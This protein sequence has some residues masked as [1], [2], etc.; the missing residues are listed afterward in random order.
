VHFVVSREQLGLT[1]TKAP[2]GALRKY[3]SAEGLR[4]PH[5]LMAYELGKKSWVSVTKDYLAEDPVFAFLRANNVE[6]YDTGV[7]EQFPVSE[8]EETVE[9]PG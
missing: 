7:L 1:Q 6:F 2:Q 9:Y 5:W 3:L 8:E 4:G